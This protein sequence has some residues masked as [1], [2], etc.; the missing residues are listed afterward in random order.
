MVRLPPLICLLSL[1]G[2]DAAPDAPTRPA[3]AVTLFAAAP[4]DPPEPEFARQAYRAALGASLAEPPGR[5][6]LEPPTG[7]EDYMSAMARGVRIARA[8]AVEES[9]DAIHESMASLALVS[10]RDCR[11]SAF[12]ASGLAPPPPGKP[13]YP[14][15]AYRCRVRVEH[16]TERRGRVAAETEGRFFREEDGWVYV[17]GAAHGF[18]TTRDLELGL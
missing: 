14:A 13:P 12:D 10:P 9:N 2:C 11:W 1:A 8:R 5:D 16:Q 17:G 15:H 4:Y 18:K 6:T 3:G 7:D